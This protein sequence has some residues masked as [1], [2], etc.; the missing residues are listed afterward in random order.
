V[1]RIERFVIFANIVCDASLESICP[2]TEGE[3]SD[4]N[5]RGRRILPW[6]SDE[7]AALSAVIRKCFDNLNPIILDGVIGK[8]PIFESKS[9][10][11]IIIFVRLEV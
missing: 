8:A 6:A 10:W 9:R 3:F 5:M 11:A 1:I 7:I 4:C 2:R